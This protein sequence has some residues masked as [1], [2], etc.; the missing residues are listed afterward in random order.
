MPFYS[1]CPITWWLL[2][3]DDHTPLRFETYEGGFKYILGIP[4][5]TDQVKLDTPVSSVGFTQSE[6]SY[7]NVNL[8]EVQSSNDSLYEIG[9]ITTKLV[10]FMASVIPDTDLANGG[11]TGLIRD[12]ERVPISARG[13]SGNPWFRWATLGLVYSRNGYVDL[14]GQNPVGITRLE[15]NAE[16]WTPIYDP[17]KS[18]P[19]NRVSRYNRA[20]VI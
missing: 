1:P 13:Y 4:I 20:W 18:A 17:P 14:F 7:I 10:N 3:Q 8:I 12:V 5:G 19:V 9:L 16:N 15:D 6:D 11:F 2:D